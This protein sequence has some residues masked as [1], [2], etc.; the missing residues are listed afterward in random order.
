M[1]IELFLVH[2]FDT[3]GRYV[4]RGR[5]I[6]GF[7]RRAIF[8]EAK[9]MACE[10]LDD[11]EVAVFDLQCLPTL[12]PYVLRLYTE[13]PVITAS[14]EAFLFIRWQLLAL[15]FRPHDI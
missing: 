8:P 6:L 13:P 9:G 3:V 5:R 2:V 7:L 15:T 14:F 11:C 4:V 12:P 10:C 1:G